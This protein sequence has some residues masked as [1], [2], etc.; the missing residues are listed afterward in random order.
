M[1]ITTPIAGTVTVALE[2]IHVP[3]NVR[4][5]D[6]AHVDALA[7]SIAW[8]GLLQPVL[9][10]PAVGEIAEQGF[11]FELTAGFHRCAA[12][13]KL[14]HSAIDAVIRE[15]DTK[16]DGADIA[17]ARAT[18]NVARKHLNAYEEAVAVA[19]M[20]ERGLTPDGAAQALGWPKARVAA[21]VKLL[22]LP[23]HSGWS[24]T[25]GSDW[26]RWISCAR[27]ARWLRGCSRR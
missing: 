17:A 20:L 14:G 19:A 7:G 13:S 3:E 27:S 16:A 2:K 23:E 4:E 25:A 26:P 8:Q 24:A 9:L 11:E 1:A 18:E 21:R 15:R 12:V 10:V 6:P 5:L 22:E